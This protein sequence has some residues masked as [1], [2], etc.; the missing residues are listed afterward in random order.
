MPGLDR[1]G[2]QGKGSRSGKGLG[3]CNS[4]G[5][6]QDA[7]NNSEERVTGRGFGAKRSKGRGQ[8]LGRSQ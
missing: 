4:R 5:E 1:T 8:G 7:Q 3:K 2:P 6:K